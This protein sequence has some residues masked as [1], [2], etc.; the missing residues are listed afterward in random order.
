MQ[1]LSLRASSLVGP[2]LLLVLAAAGIAQTPPADEVGKNVQVLPKDMPKTEIVKRMKE[3]AGDLGVK[4]GFCHVPND[5]P[6]DVKG[7]K[8]VAREMMKMVDNINATT[9]K[10]SKVKVRCF[11]CHRG[12]EEPQVAPAS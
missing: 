8:L 10:D 6:S 1:R 12:H 5:A 2:A 3:V 9:L 4:C 11:T 7:T